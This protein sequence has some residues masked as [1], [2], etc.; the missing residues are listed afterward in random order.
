MNGPGDDRAPVSPG[1]EPG[2]RGSA[3]GCHHL[4]ESFAFGLESGLYPVSEVA[5]CGFPVP[6]QA[7]EWRAK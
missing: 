3:E 5:E 6:V 7:V 1:F 4:V 2:G